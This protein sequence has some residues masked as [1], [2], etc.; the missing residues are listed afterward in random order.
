MNRRRQILALIQLRELQAWSESRVL[1][2]HLTKV[3]QL[4][5]EGRRTTEKLA[6]VEEQWADLCGQSQLD[7]TALTIQQ[8]RVF[9]CE[10]ELK[11]CDQALVNAQVA[12]EC[13]HALY[14]QALADVEVAKRINEVSTKADRKR[15]ESKTQNALQDRM[16]QTWG[17]S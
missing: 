1:S 16:S 13:A 5:D 10:A 15:R 6:Q 3:R 11:E 7:L 12:E 8:A 2:E 14:A 4:E 17:R 9:Q